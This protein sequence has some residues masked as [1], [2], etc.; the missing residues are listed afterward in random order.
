MYQ[1][2]LEKNTGTHGGHKILESVHETRNIG[3][4]NKG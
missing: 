4:N 3:D 1:A 2:P